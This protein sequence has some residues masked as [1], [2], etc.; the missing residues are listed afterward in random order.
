MELVAHLRAARVRLGPSAS[1]EAM[2]ERLQEVPEF[3]SCWSAH[4]VAETRRGE[5]RVLHPDAGELRLAFEVLLLPDDGDQRLITWMPAD[6]QTAQALAILTSG[7][8][9]RGAGRGRLRVVGES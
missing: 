4:A 6:D 7:A 5:Q 1:F 8:A 3:A 9:A 2:L